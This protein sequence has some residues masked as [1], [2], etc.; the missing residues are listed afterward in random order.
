MALGMEV[1]LGPGHIMLDGDPASLPKKRSAAEPPI[2]GAFL[3]WPNIWMHQDATWYGGRPKTRRHCVRWGPSSPLPKGHSPQ[4]LDHF[5]CGQMAVCIRIPLGTEV[6]LS[7]GDIVLD[8]DPAPL[9]LKGH[10]PQ[11][12][13]N[14][15]CGQIRLSYS[16]ICAE[17]GVK[18]QLT[19]CCGQIAGWTKMPLGMEVGL[20]PGDFVFD[21]D[22]APPRKSAQHPSNFWPMS[23]VAIRLDGSRCHLVWR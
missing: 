18:L 12:S 16:R 14:V 3:L 15:C 7:L 1:G 2:F 19:N 9:P 17:N 11:F 21:G 10:S 20:G 8:G 13:A 23:V 4:F 22:P 6:G 5:Y